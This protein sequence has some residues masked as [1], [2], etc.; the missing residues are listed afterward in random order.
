MLGQAVRVSDGVVIDDGALI[1]MPTEAWQVQALVRLASHQD[2]CIV[3]RGM[4]SARAGG[5]VALYDGGKRPIVVD[6]TINQDIQVDV[7]RHTISVGCGATNEDVQQAASAC[8]LFYPVDAYRYSTMG[9]NIAT[10]AYG[11]ESL[12]YGTTKDYVLGLDLILPDGERMTTRSSVTPMGIDLT[13]LLVGSEGTLGIIWSATLRLLDMP[14]RTYTYIAGFD[15][16]DAAF[17]TVDLLLRQYR[18]AL[19]SLDFMD[20][21]TTDA[22]GSEYLADQRGRYVLLARSRYESM[23]GFTRVDDRD[24]V[25]VW[26]AY[27]NL[28][29]VD[30]VRV[31]VD[32]TDAE[33]LNHY[34]VHL[35]AEHSCEVRVNGSAGLG[36]FHVSFSSDDSKVIAECNARTRSHVMSILGG[37]LAVEGIGN[38]GNDLFISTQTDAARLN[39]KIKQALDPLG[40]MN[41][42]KVL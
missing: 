28:M 6:L 15:T 18:S 20:A 26:D 3:P 2:L 41:P 31:C 8:D 9:G 36:I 21:L 23:P 1:A 42:K 37:S 7:L 12:A 32:T 35:A 25:F 39:L 13:R 22:I 16:H 27:Y 19:T 17:R 10:D 40:I 34:V 33:L 38:M 30:A 5:A 24:A 14:E 4:G 29:Y 11:V